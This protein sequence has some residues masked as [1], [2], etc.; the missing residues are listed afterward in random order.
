MRTGKGAG[1][2]I[3]GSKSRVAIVMG[4]TIGDDHTG[5]MAHMINL[6]YTHKHGYD[7]IVERNPPNSESMRFASTDKNGIGFAR[8]LMLMKALVHYDYAVYMDS[9]ARTRGHADGQDARTGWTDMRGLPLHS[10]PAVCLRCVQSLLLSLT[11]LSSPVSLPSDAYVH[12]FAQTVESF[13]EQSVAPNASLAIGADCLWHDACWTADL[14]TGVIFA[15][16]GAETTRLLEA[17]ALAPAPGNFCDADRETDQARGH[18]HAH[19]HAPN[20]C[21][22]LPTASYG[23]AAHA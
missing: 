18:G 7:M 5:E 1:P 14:N 12:D 10:P 22:R 15:R 4:N 19:P 3:G 20:A 13:F 11:P 17:W 23:C 9:G 8:P 6:L 16:R 21:T 2:A